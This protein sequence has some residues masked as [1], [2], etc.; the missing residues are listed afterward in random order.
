M[1]RIFGIIAIIL[2]TIISFSSFAQQKSDIV[3][4]KFQ[5]SGTCSMCKKRIE[6]A[7]YIPGVKRAEWSKE[8]KDLTV[9]FKSSKASLQQI[10][11]SIAKA[12]HD[13]EGLKA[14]DEDYKKLPECCAYRENASCDE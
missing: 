7:A 9:T 2:I 8:T 1:K 3:T 13:V 5:V 11:Q 4:E 10:K 14:T 6:D 12:G